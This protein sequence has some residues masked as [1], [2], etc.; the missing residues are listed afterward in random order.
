MRFSVRVCTLVTAVAAAAMVAA[1]LAVPAGAAAGPQCA[2]LSTKTVKTTVTATVSKCTPTTA[3]GGTGSGTFT[4]S[5]AKSGTLNI[6]L[7]W[8]AKDGTTK[9]N[10]KFGPA[11]GLGKCP[12]GTTSRVTLTGSIT[13]GT[14]T[15]VKTI[16]AGQKIAASVCIGKTSD[17]LQPGTV[18][19]I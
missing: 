8:A 18:L 19:T 4:S 5:G 15:A 11:T 10:V 17:T 6:T 3:T 9:G 16:K 14:G 2:A 13:G 1:P 7:T 12:K